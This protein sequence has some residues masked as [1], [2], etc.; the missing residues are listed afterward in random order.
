MRKRICWVGLLLP[1]AVSVCQASDAGN[2]HFVGPEPCALCHK[3]VAAELGIS[4]GTIK[5]HMKNILPKLSATDRT[6]AVMIAL[7]RGILDL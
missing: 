6:H 5:T 7:K 1:L 2:A 3:E 4:E